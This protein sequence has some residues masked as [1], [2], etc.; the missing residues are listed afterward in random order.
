MV[1]AIPFENKKQFYLN[2]KQQFFGV[3]GHVR[4]GDRTVEAT[5]TETAILD[6]G[7]GVWPFSHEWFWG[8]GAALMDGGR[9]GFNIG[10]GFGDLS[11]TGENMFF[12]N[13]KA[14][15]VGQLE[16]DRD[17]NNYTAPWHFRS[18]D[19][20]LD[21]TMTPIFD[22]QTATK[23]LFVN[24]SCHQVFGHF[25]GTAQLPDGQIIKVKDMV[26]FCEHAVNHW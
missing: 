2:N 19:G 20:L 25:N 14:Y 24:N 12:W 8:N 10:W 26:A 11:A 4:F 6:W 16:V 15:K 5:G 7:R 13:G 17:P 23:V 22:H 3:T 9:F 18:N 21:L 1:I